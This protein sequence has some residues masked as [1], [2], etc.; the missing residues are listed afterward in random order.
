MTAP[1]PMKLLFI[2]D[3]ETFAQTVT[4][5]FLG[6]HVVERAT[7]LRAA[8]AMMDRSFDAVLLDYDLPDGK[9]D[10]FGRWAREKGHRAPFVACSSHEDGNALLLDAGANEVCAKGYFARIQ[11]VLERLQP[12]PTHEKMPVPIPALLARALSAALEGPPSIEQPLTLLFDALLFGEKQVWECH[13]AAIIT[14][15]EYRNLLLAH[16]DTLVEGLA[17]HGLS[18]TQR[19]LKT[20]PAFEAA[21]FW[22]SPPLQ[23]LN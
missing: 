17:D 20:V 2:E 8:Q 16:A 12:M 4:A 22:P 3:H 23:S 19:V 11:S 5:E 9:G 10:A 13:R 15:T 6:A 14:H 21:L 7:T 1:A 18:F